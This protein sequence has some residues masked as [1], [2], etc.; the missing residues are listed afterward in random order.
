MPQEIA[1]IPLQNKIQERESEKTK[2]FVG[3]SGGVDSGTSAAILKER[4]YD[5]AGVFIK[6]WQPEFIECTWREDRLDAMRIAAALD[7][8]F[9]EIDLSHEYKTEIVEHMVRD[10]ERGITPN[11]DVLCN[12]KIKFGHFAQWAFA[13]GADLIATGHYARV[14]PAVISQTYHHGDKSDLSPQ[15][16]RGVDPLKD[17]SY[18][19][20]RVRTEELARTLFPIGDL[21]K[22]EVRKRAQACGLPVAHKP[23]SQGL[24]FVGDVSMRDFLARYITLKE[25]DVIDTDGNKIG[26]HDGAALYTIGQRHGFRVSGHTEGAQYVI[27]TS[28]KD[29]TVTVSLDRSLGEVR[30]IML[31]DMHWIGETPQLPLSTLAQSRHR[32]APFPVSLRQADDGMRV[33]FDA[34]HL[35]SSGQSL[36]LYDDDR[37]FG[38]GVIRRI[39]RHI[40]AL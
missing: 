15:L 31:E 29:N 16:M 20:C 4:G 23:D 7:I 13:H 34:P 33:Q 3:L 14:E 21:S 25:G 18:F 24:C 17:Q 1:T 35:V 30:E 10:Y 2:V 28:I 22:S 9:R 8:P 32:E 36:V 26:T 19:L 38:A 40:E 5:V 27:A 6:I 12:E 11:P 39:E 37:V